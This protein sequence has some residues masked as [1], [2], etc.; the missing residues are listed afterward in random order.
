MRYAMAMVVRGACPPRAAG[1]SKIRRL[2]ARQTKDPEISNENGGN[3]IK[4]LLSR[5]NNHRP[6][7]TM[8]TLKH[9][10]AIIYSFRLIILMPELVVDKLI[11]ADCKCLKSSEYH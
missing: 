2:D 5:Q 7:K 6:P 11:N 1:L 10:S 4:H 3:I 9:Q 8:S